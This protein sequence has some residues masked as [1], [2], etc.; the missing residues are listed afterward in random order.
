MTQDF[1]AFSMW[2]LFR[3]ELENLVAQLNDGLL[4]LESGAGDRKSIVDALMRASHS[5]KGAARIVKADDL[6]ELA[7]IMEDFFINSTQK[8]SKIPA[9]HIDVLLAAADTFQQFIDIEES[10]A[11]EALK[12]KSASVKTISEKIQTFQEIEKNI[13]N[14]D[15]INGGFELKERK[16]PLKIEFDPDKFS[17]DESKKALKHPLFAMFAE[18]VKS[19]CE[20][21]QLLDIATKAEEAESTL[22]AIKGASKLINY[23]AVT[24]FTNGVIQLVRATITG[25]FSIVEVQRILKSTCELLKKSITAEQLADYITEAPNTIKYALESEGNIDKPSSAAPPKS[26]PT[27]AILDTESVKDGPE[28]II[29]KP[30]ANKATDKST[31]IK[32]AADNM[33][34]L[35][36]LS[37]E[38]IVATQKLESVL[39]DLLVLKRKQTEFELWLSNINESLSAAQDSNEITEVLRSGLDEY[40]YIKNKTSEITDGLDTFVHT[41]KNLTNRVHREVMISRMRPFKDITHGFQRMIRDLS[42]KLGKSIHLNILGYDT[43]L[44]RD[45]LEKLE[46]PLTHLLRNAADH[47]MELPAER[48][49]LGKI[50]EGTISLEA[51]HSAGMLKITISDDGKGVNKE[52]L[53]KKV[54]D[55]NN[56]PIHVISKMND[57]ELYDF[58]FLPGFST[59]GQVTEISGRGVGLDVVHH[60]VQ[61]VGGQ[62][63]MIS[64]EG[65]YTQITLIL[66]LTLSVIRT[67]LVKIGTEIYAF[68]LTRI[69]QVLIL[70]REQIKKA[71]GKYY[72]NYEQEQI[73]LISGTQVL[74][75]EEKQLDYDALKVL[76]V[77]DRINKFGIVADELL[78]Q[79]EIVVQPL[80][81]RLG[82]LPNIQAASTIDDG[83]PVLIVDIEDIVRSVHNILHEGREFKLGGA[84]HIKKSTYKRILVVEDSITVRELQRRLIMNNGY[85]VDVAVDGMDGWNT[86]RS[87]NYDLIITDIDMPRMNGIDLLKKIRTEGKLTDIP[88]IIVSYKDSEKDKL[89]G[90]NAG[91]NY[92]LT[93]SS[94]HDDTLLNAIRDLIGE[95]DKI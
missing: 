29:K 64:D 41:V 10:D 8:V 49:A 38:S 47:G 92:Y 95:S 87:N 48:L 61:E 39:S 83:V 4:Q 36:G 58:L 89:A 12:D 19:N 35:I 81:P 73:G 66:P 88:V 20:R 15:A 86:Y 75:L 77:S 22:S 34:R 70:D 24:E 16:Q 18:E 45:I 53:R 54:A 82:K 44:D 91:A 76:I 43:K 60:L 5:I 62:Y 3:A 6:V 57:R 94:F 46:A 90:M 33:S 9:A 67:M 30:K 84:A 11:V 1:S 26:T 28:Q 65:K 17:L 2:E 56:I 68:P 78:N 31:V 71:D 55:R 42:R 79:R 52:K 25:Q 69:D 72:F 27:T 21:L 40:S 23:V 50:K 85:E 63:E 80:D 93:K 32:V 59:A 37:G 7:H 51:S 13:Q 74:G 14:E